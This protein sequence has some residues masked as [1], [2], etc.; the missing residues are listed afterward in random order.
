MCFCI[1]IYMK[2]ERTTPTTTTRMKTSS[3]RTVVVVALLAAATTIVTVV[4]MA[5]P[6]VVKPAYAQLD[7]N[8]RVGEIEIPDSDTIRERVEEITS[9]QPVPTLPEQASPLGRPWIPPAFAG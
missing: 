4:G 9:S 5:L 8:E 7:I 6:I 3:R 1:I 2:G